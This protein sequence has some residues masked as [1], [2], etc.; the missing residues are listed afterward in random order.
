MA[1]DGLRLDPPPPGQRRIEVGSGYWPHPGYVHVDKVPTAAAVDLVAS[2]HR[3][4]L[5]DQWADELLSV[6]MIEHVAP[7]FLASTLEEWHRVLRPGGTLTIHTPNG[8][9][10]ARCLLALDDADSPTQWA[11]QNAVYG[12]WLGPG[13][14]ATPTNFTARPD[15]KVLLSFGLLEA[16]LDRAGFAQ[17]ADV[18]GRDPCHHRQDWAPLVP[19]LCLEVEARRSA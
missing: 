3:L 15:H 7:P 14:A 12:Y 2:G 8:E 18:T 11:I 10:L 9:S 17:V 16:L 5:A 6:H 1:R 19:G 13:D 4:P